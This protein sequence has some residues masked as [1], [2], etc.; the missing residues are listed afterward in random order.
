V[1]AQGSL[2]MKRNMQRVMM[3]LVLGCMNAVVESWKPMLRIRCLVFVLSCASYSKTLLIQYMIIQHSVNF[4]VTIVSK[5]TK[6]RFY[7]F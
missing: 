3:H 1:L 6:L 7:D 5:P 4:E 2:R